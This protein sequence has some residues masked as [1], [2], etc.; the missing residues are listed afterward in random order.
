MEIEEKRFGEMLSI[1]NAGEQ[2]EGLERRTY[3]RIPL[4]K[5][6]AV[7]PFRDG[8]EG[9]L[10]EVWMRDISQGGIGL[11][12]TE[13]MHRGDE[14]LVHLPQGERMLKVRCRVTYCAPLFGQAGNGMYG[15]GARFVEELASLPDGL[16]VAS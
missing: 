14:F 10:L 3:P 1:L 7:I 2:G 13:P 15:I 16:T 5:C 9:D 6:M 8:Q 11:V 4:Q 12:H